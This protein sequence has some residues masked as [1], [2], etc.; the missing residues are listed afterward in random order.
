MKIASS[1]VFLSSQHAAVEQT[2]TRESLRMWIGKQ[3]PN[4][5]NAPQQ[6]PVPQDKVS[7]SDA[8]KAAQMNDTSKAS[9]ADKELQ[10]DPRMMLI[11]AMIEAMTGQKIRLLSL[12]DLQD[13]PPDAP[14]QQ[15][16]PQPTEQ[17]AP[18]PSAGFGVEYDYHQSYYES[19]QTQFSAQGVIKTA[20]GKEISFSLQLDMS[21]TYSSETDVSLRLGDAPKK[22][23]PLAINFAGTAAQLTE[24]KF[25]FDL[26]TDGKADQVSFLA[27]GSGFLALDKNGDGIINSGAE[28]FGPSTGQGF[29]EL[30]AYD[31][32]HNN[33]IGENDK[34]YSDLRLF[35]KDAQGNDVLTTLKQANVGAIFLGN[36]ATPFDIK[37]SQQNLNGQV[38]ASGVYLSDSGSAGSVQ[39]VDLTV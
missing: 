18:Q 30:A 6:Q 35:N 19:E 32:D 17:P 39:Q 7:I 10:G 1:E 31:Q 23:D 13:T 22:T 4:F 20:D 33:W 28:L 8:A 38:R 27:G 3:R 26:N 21:Q 34:V 36:V 24:S 29:Q 12:K 37:D 11:K 16:A 5:E 9:A 15:A 14:P 2:V 25:S